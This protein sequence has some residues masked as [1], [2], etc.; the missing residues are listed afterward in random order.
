M[1][2]I[3]IKDRKPQPNELVYQGP[4]ETGCECVFD[5]KQVLIWAGDPTFKHGAL[6]VFLSPEEA[7]Q[8]AKQLLHHAAS[9]ESGVPDED[10]SMC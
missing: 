1:A 10:R 9:I 8:V 7:R 4:A 2:F 5:E 6:E 3:R